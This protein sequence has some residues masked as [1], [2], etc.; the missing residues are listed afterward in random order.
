MRVV[1]IV[2]ARMGSTRLP[3]KVMMPIG[4]IPMIGVLLKRLSFS[5]QIDE[6]VLATSHD[7]KNDVMVSYV[8]SLGFGCKRGSESDVLGRFLDTAAAYSADIIVR[9]TGDCPLVDA[10]LVDEAIKLFKNSDV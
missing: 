4:N 1:A 3:N 2:Q 7:K 10:V 6:I 9:I 5:K 8:Q